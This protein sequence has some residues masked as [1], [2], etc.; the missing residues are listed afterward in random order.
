M[1]PT[2]ESLR[3][4]LIIYRSC[5]KDIYAT[6]LHFPSILNFYVI[7]SYLQRNY[8]NRKYRAKA[9]LNRSSQCCLLCRRK[10]AEGLKRCKMSTTERFCVPDFIESF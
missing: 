3:V 5:C 1:S 6:P 9:K 4:N 8:E 2:D 7:S 10:F